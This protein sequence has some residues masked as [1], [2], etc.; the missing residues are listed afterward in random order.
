[1]RADAYPDIRILQAGR[2]DD[3]GGFKP[4]ANVWMC[5]ALPWDK[6]DPALLQCERNMGENELASLLA[7]QE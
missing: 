1:M 4:T 3:P 2:F 6:P 5:N 7:Q